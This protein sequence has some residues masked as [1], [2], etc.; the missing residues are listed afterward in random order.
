MI[1]E[2]RGM[3]WAMMVDIRMMRLI[4]V[5]MISLMHRRTTLN[6]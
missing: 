6:R 5:M 4:V 3:E 2:A 1:K